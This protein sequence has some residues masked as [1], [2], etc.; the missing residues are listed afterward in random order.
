MNY[1]LWLT[2]LSATFAVLERVRPRDPQ[3]RALRPGLLTDLFYAVWNGHFLGVALALVTEPLARGLDAALAARGMSLH[4]R[5]A[6]DW[7]VWVQFPVALVATDLMQW[8]IH[9]LLHRVPTLWELHKV[10]HSIRTM[11]FWGSLRFHV[12][13][14]VVYKSLLYVP[15]ALL[16]FDP[17]L[18]F[19]LAIVSTAIGHFNHANLRV[20]MGPLRYVLNGPEMHVWHHAHPDAG[21]TNVNF[22]INLAVWDW[23]FG[24]AW[25]P[26]V[27]ATPDT[28]GFSG[29]EDFARD[30]LGQTLSPLAR[31]CGR[32]SPLPRRAKMR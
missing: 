21:P 18:S 8:A 2:G 7:P 24:T 14:V 15:L 28:L 5:L 31:A 1:W 16:G 9:N 17:A 12:G 4:V 10:H 11:D 6:A 13:E 22:A 3:Q 19:A 23:L 29:V 30:P 26:P 32:T 27:A 25:L 20:R